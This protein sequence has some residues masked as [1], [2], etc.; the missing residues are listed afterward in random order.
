MSTKLNPSDVNLHLKTHESGPRRSRSTGTTPRSCGRR[1]PP[2]SF[3]VREASNCRKLGR[4]SSTSSGEDDDHCKIIPAT[5]DDDFLERLDQKVTEVIYRSRYGNI[6]ADVDLNGS[7][8]DHYGPTSLN[9]NPRTLSKKSSP[10]SAHRISRSPRT[11]VN[12]SSSTK[13]AETS[14]NFEGNVKFSKEDEAS[15]TVESSPEDFDA[16]E[17]TTKL[18]Y[19]RWSDT[20]G[21]NNLEGC[22]VSDESDPDDERLA[23]ALR[24]RR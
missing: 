24:R 1:H 6:S 3:Y 15:D 21:N 22:I 16:V 20:E 18:S 8:L 19:G 11:T 7:N 4:D 10:G 9:Q 14:T 17:N 12:N 13:M 5:P 2:E 23:F